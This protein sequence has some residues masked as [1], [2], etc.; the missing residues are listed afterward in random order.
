MS[1]AAKTGSLERAQGFNERTVI[2]SLPTP[3]RSYRTVA[4]LAWQK[5]SAVCFE[6]TGLCEETID[7]YQGLT[8]DG[9]GYDDEI[10]D[11][12][13]AV[14]EIESYEAEISELACRIEHGTAPVTM[15]EQLPEIVVG[16][17]LEKHNVDLVSR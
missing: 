10:N 5:V 2:M 13:A 8:N 4:V 6:Y 12:L 9:Y 7:V 11:L 1:E 15:P 3:V 17:I 16:D 14:E